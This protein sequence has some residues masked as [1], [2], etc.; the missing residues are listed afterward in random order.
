M[1]QAFDFE[2]FGSP[3]LFAGTNAYVQVPAS[4]SLDVGTGGGFSLEGWICLTN[5]NQPQ[6]IFEWISRVP[7]NTAI[8]NISIAEGPFLNPGN[9]YYYYLLA[10]T[11]WPTSEAWAEELGG[12]LVTMTTANLEN[13]VY[14]TFTDY[15]ATNRYLW[16]GLTNNPGGLPAFA[17]SSGLTNMVYTNWLATQPNNCDNLDFFTLILSPTNTEPGLWA[18]ADANGFICGDSATNLVYGVV[19]LT[20][21]P[22]IG[23]QFWACATNSYDPNVPVAPSPGGLE[24]I[25]PGAAIINGVTNYGEL[26]VSSAPGLLQTNVFQ[27]VVLS[28]STNTG[29]ARLYLN[30]T[31]VPV[32]LVFTNFSTSVGAGASNAFVL[33][34]NTSGDLF[35]GR[36]LTHYT[37]NYFGGLMDEMSVYGRALSDAEILA[38]YSD[39]ANT[40]NRTIGKFDPAVTPAAGLAEA[41][42]TFGTVS[43]V[44]YGVNNQWEVN[45]YTFT[46]TSNSMPLTISGL[47]PGIL[48]D[49]FAVEEAPQTNLYYLPEQDLSALNGDSANGN[50][51]L[52]IWDNRAGAYVPTADQLVNWD[53]SLVLV[54]QR[55]D[56]GLAAAA[57]AGHHHAAGGPDGLLL[58]DGARLGERRDQPSGRLRPA[59]EP[60]LFQPRQRAEWFRQPAGCHFAEP[61]RPAAS[62]TRF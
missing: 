20:N 57:D 13:W 11:N 1:D 15:G 5:V 39:S 37:N 53:L 27:H 29:L 9:G 7:T 30:G 51:T 23:V 18:L 49:S 61:A 41:L 19:E 4:P 46:A 42:V 48:L 21:L 47:E 31:N 28:Y 55:G 36:D 59:G 43:N 32:T 2:D 6:P 26:L 50:W 22:P 24:G 12:H 45:S 14:D 58:G 56:L 34:P 62:A 44:I 3:Y 33:Q 35:L 52:Q 54:I 25:L 38:I 8:T 16:I 40:T 60:A 10:P 17:W